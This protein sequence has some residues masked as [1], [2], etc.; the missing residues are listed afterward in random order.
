MNILLVSIY[1]YQSYHPLV[2]EYWLMFYTFSSTTRKSNKT[3]SDRSPSCL[4][5]IKSNCTFRTSNRLKP[6]SSILW[7]KQI[8]SQE[9]NSTITNVCLS[10]RSLTKPLF[11]QHPSSFIL[12][13][14]ISA[15]IIIVYLYQQ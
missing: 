6:C 11:I 10:V 1:Q 14:I 4:I 5:G 3:M 8:F 12:Y 2:N 13:F 7:K 15:E 9:S